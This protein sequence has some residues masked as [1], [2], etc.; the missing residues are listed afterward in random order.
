MVKKKILMLLFG[1]FLPDPRVLK[2]ANALG[3]S[4]YEVLVVAWNRTGKAPHVKSYSWFKVVHFPP[5]LP[6]N[7][8]KLQVPFQAL[9]KA[10]C[11]LSFSIRTIRFALKGEWDIFYVHDLDTLHIG[12]FLKIRKRKK[13]I[14]DSHEYY[15]DLIGDRIG[16]RVVKPILYWEKMLC[17]QVDQIIT[18]NEI[19]AEKFKTKHKRV[20]VIRNAVD[21]RWFDTSP[22]HY[23]SDNNIPVVIYVGAITK[24]RGIKEFVLSKKYLKNK[25]IYQII[26]HG[27]MRHTIER[28]IQTEELNGVKII[29]WVEFEKVPFHIKHA[30]IGI[31]PYQPVP[32]YFHVTPTKMFEYI[33]GGLPVVATN[34]PEIKRVI[35]DCRCGL[36][37]D[38][39]KPRDIAEKLDYLIEHPEESRLMG[40]RG[41]K[42]VEEQFNW[43]DEELKLKE[44][45]STILGDE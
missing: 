32:N 14:Y 27:T 41:R 4:G 16:N 44:I 34:L 26:G 35:Y 31:M 43:C 9:I 36:F 21:L 38:P 2:E 18:V 22:E 12:A 29:P 23:S 1:E 37:I 3:R 25:A 10:R 33:A 7:F 30:D 17:R 28:M 5:P 39:T 24:N 40:K 45:L 8:S 19:L 13:L 42:Y 15:S 20:G 11:L 6:K